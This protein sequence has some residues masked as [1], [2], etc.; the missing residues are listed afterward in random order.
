MLKFKVLALVVGVALGVAACGGEDSGVG[1]DDAL[2]AIGDIAE[3][4][5]GDG[6]S[7]SDDS[8]QLSENVTI[9]L[10]GGGTL[11][12]SIT[13]TGYGYAY[14]EYS[15]DKYDEIVD[16]YNDW[17]VTDSRDWSGFDSSFESQG[18][19]VRGWIWDSSGTRFG[20]ADCV[21]GGG[22]GAFN[23]AC[24]KISEWEE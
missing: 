4:A 7:S 6:G 12:A 2:G 23:A 8:L 11:T 14:V 20:V 21:A 5:G 9:P 13:D 22:A 10:V 16:F 1:G 17:V 24:V 15:A 3:G 19:V 18:A